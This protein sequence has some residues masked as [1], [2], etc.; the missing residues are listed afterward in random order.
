MCF[1]FNKKKTMIFKL[2]LFKDYKEE[3]EQNELEL[4]LETQPEG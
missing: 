3:L 2:F 1:D 4:E